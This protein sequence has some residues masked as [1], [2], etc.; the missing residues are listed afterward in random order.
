MKFLLVF[1]YKCLI[2]CWMIFFL[3]KRQEKTSPAKIFCAG[4]T[5][6]DKGGPSVKVARLLKVFQAGFRYADCVYVTSGSFYVFSW[7]WPLVARKIPILVNQNGVYKPDWYVGNWRGKNRDLRILLENANYVFY[8]SEFCKEQ[9]TTYVGEIFSP[10]EVLFNAVDTR[11]FSPLPEVPSP[12]RR[13]HL[14]VTGNFVL[15]TADRLIWA[16][17]LVNY[18]TR[19]GVL[20]SLSIRGFCA[21]DL[22]HELEGEFG[23]RHSNDNIFWGGFFSQDEAPQVYRNADIFLLF[24]EG[25]SCPNTVI[26]AMA[27]GCPVL[28]FDSGGTPELVGEGGIGIRIARKNPEGMLEEM[29]KGVSQINVNREKFRLGARGRATSRFSIDYWYQRHE[30]IIQEFSRSE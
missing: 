10:G 12:S 27:C 8:Q 17:R 24:K 25:D 6:G 1:G 14:L 3:K 29:M 2:T 11:V 30:A 23:N 16:M 26:E 4:A 19:H 13:T 9:V 21:E 7:A 18:L 22:L 5:S 15:A 28:Y 20:A